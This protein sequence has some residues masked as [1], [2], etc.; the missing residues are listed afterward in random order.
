MPI[1][2]IDQDEYVDSNDKSVDD[3][4]NDDLEPSTS[5]EARIVIIATGILGAMLILVVT[6]I[7]G[8]F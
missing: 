8:I 2:V 1:Q 7:L 5:R 6:A 3:L 4:T